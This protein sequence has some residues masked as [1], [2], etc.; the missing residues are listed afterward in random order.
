MGRHVARLI[1]REL[2]SDSQ[3]VRGAFRYFDKGTMA[4]IGR[5]AAVAKIGRFECSGFIAWLLWLFVHLIFLIGFR[6]KA[7]VLLQWGYSYLTYKRGARIITQAARSNL[8]SAQAN[9]PQG[10][11]GRINGGEKPAVVAAAPH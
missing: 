6:N 11:H 10:S 2:E 1:E 3:S 9:P 7:A 5:S 4:T 8:P